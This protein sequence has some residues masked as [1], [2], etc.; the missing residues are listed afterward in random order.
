MN[1]PDPTM[2]LEKA[3]ELLGSMGAEMRAFPEDVEAI[4]T[5]LQHLETLKR[6]ME[7]IHQIAAYPADCATDLAGDPER[8]WKLRER[9]ADMSFKCLPP[10]PQQKGEA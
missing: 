3:T 7:E 2:T 9:I 1:T 6:G 5:I 4:E 8:E 10:A